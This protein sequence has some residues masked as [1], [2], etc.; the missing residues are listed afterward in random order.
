[1]REEGPIRKDLSG[2]TDA[3][4]PYIGAARTLLGQIKNQMRLGGLQQLARSVVLPDGTTIRAE[5]RMG[6]DTVR[7]VGPSGEEST[8]APELIAVPEETVEVPEPPTIEPPEIPGQKYLMAIFNNNQVAAIPMESLGG[9]SWPVVYMAHMKQGGLDGT[10][11]TAQYRFRLAGADS[12]FL[13]PFSLAGKDPVIAPDS[14]LWLNVIRSND[15]TNPNVVT[16]VRVDEFTNGFGLNWMPH[17]NAKGSTVYLSSGSY[18]YTGSELI[19]LTTNTAA[20]Y[21]PGH[22]VFDDGRVRYNNGVFQGY[23]GTLGETHFDYVQSIFSPR[24]EPLYQAM[25]EKLW[26][27]Y[28]DGFPFTAI[29]AGAWG[30]TLNGG[31]GEVQTIGGPYNFYVWLG[32]G[33]PPD[34]F[35]GTLGPKQTESGD[36]TTDSEDVAMNFVVSQ[37]QQS[38][39]YDSL[40]EKIVPVTGT[41]YRYEPWII[42]FVVPPGEYVRGRGVAQ[43]IATAHRL[44]YDYK[45]TLTTYYID[46]PYTQAYSVSGVSPVFY[47]SFPP[48]PPTGGDHVIAYYANPDGVSLPTHGI[49][50]TPYFSQPCG[51]ADTLMG[52][53]HLSNGR[54]YLQGYYDFT[55]SVQR[56][57]YDGVEVSGK[58]AAALKTDISS[59][60]AIL[61]DIPLPLIKRL[62]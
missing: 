62:K 25:H 47:K 13:A 57:F 56:L 18:S 38:G 26:Q 31:V 5:S 42:T 8:L 55:N 22:F 46:L 9:A 50:S 61:I 27:G 2:D 40:V 30:E 7:I 29:L 16:S 52:W 20:P 3:A 1:M 49:W 21:T 19:R 43:D 28:P 58:L 15:G 23:L 53:L 35:P 32:G 6:Q 39:G 41:V 34:T 11:P 48:T 24:S 17:L 4:A 37:L 51:V 59:V 54:H 36:Y 44:G 33:T 12:A 45:F 14:Q 60:Q 10:Y